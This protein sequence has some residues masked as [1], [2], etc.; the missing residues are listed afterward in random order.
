MRSPKY[1]SPSSIAT[2]EK[3]RTE[4]YLRYLAE[5]RP[6]RLPQTKQMAIGAA[7]DA[8]VKSYLVGELKGRDSDPRFELQTIFE[9]QVEPHNRT[10]AF[11]HGKWAFKCYKKSGALADLMLVLQDAL[12]E[13][14]F[15]F[16][17][18]GRIAHETSSDGIPL[19]GKPDVFYRA[20]NSMRVVHDWKVNGFYSLH[21][22]SPRKGYVLS[23]DGWD[24]DA[25]S[26]S[27]R[28]FHK[29]AQI[30]VMN[31]LHVNCAHYL[32]DIDSSWAD[33]LAIYGWV[34][35]E[36]I[37]SPFIACIEQLASG[38]YTEYV[39]PKIRVSS[40][41]NKI[42]TTY[43]CNLF[44]RIANI[45]KK[46]QDCILNKEPFFDNMT[47]EESIER[48]KSLDDYYLAF[49]NTG[50]DKDGW[51]QDITRSQ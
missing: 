36:P 14:K 26:R 17:I 5:N 25:H 24:D 51:F 22:T 33:Q 4:F 27:H 38:G 45:W 41:R 2:F 16:E 29:D 18:E 47:L 31:G 8:F 35:G 23:R 6:P 21:P 19:L 48:C 9:N 30:I 12:E 7:F 40:Y 46:I 28:T 3:D 37:G 44:T 20:K 34:L 39:L 13:P 1:L 11:S 42:S 15:E 10:L 50:E 49:L 32:E 43:Q